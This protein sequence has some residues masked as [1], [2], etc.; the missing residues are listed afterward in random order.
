MSEREPRL[1][2]TAPNADSWFSGSPK[3]NGACMHGS[4][5]FA[6]SCCIAGRDQGASTQRS[7]DWGQDGSMSAG[8][9]HGQS[10]GALFLL[11]KGTKS[12]SAETQR[13]QTRARRRGKERG[14]NEEKRSNVGP[15]EVDR[16][17]R[18]CARTSAR[19]CF[20]VSKPPMASEHC[21]HYAPPTTRKRNKWGLPIRPCEGGR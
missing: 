11:L 21:H 14:I 1:S 5:W 12:K 19:L 17:P 18:S 7:N 15:G 6:N 8:L 9:S 20:L 16:A 2:G 3:P 4:E 13:V 10:P